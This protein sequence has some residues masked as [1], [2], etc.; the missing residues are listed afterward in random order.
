MLM[1]YIALVE[2]KKDYSVPKQ[3]VQRWLGV[4]HFVD[5]LNIKYESNMH[6]NTMLLQEHYYHYTNPPGK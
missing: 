1:S 4:T 6:T 2:S 5:K 3:Y